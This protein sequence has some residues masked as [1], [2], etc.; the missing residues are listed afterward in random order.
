MLANKLNTQHLSVSELNNIAKNCLESNFSQVIVLG[1]V[2]KIVNHSSGHW[3]FTIK[4]DASSVDCTMFA[5]FNRNKI[6]PNVGNKII[7]IGKLTIYPAS[8]KYQINCTNLMIED[9]LGKL[10]E[11]LNKLHAKLE[12]EGLFSDIYKKPIPK[13][14]T[15]LAIITA[16]DSAAFNDILRVYE[17]KQ[18]YLCKIDFYYSLMQG[19]NAS[20]NIIFNINKI[21]EKQYD[22]ILIARGGGSKEDLFCFNDEFLVRAIVNSKIPVITGLGHEI[23][24]HLSDLAASKYY[25]TPTAAMDS[26]CY[27]KDERMIYLDSLE[28][29]INKLIRYKLNK[30]EQN[31]LYLNSKFSKKDAIIKFNSLK[32]HLLFKNKLLKQNMKNYI[33]KQDYKIKNAKALIN[34]S[35][36][37]NIYH[38]NEVLKKYSQNFNLQKFENLQ[39]KIKLNL[40]SYENNYKKSLNNKLLK[41]QN[42]LINFVNQKEKIKFKLK[43]ENNFIFNKEK[44]FFSIIKTNIKEKNVKIS[45]YH[46]V[47]NAHQA[48]FESVKEYARIIKNGKG[49]MLSSLQLGD[50]IVLKSLDTQKV[51]KIIKE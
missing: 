49:V 4:D 29:K 36:K 22:A 20:K 23:D 35:I 2:S 32:N 45:N 47:L 15:K 21:N 12:K 1:E 14:I 24:I 37:N 28:D 48:F 50:E 11:Q 9:K 30:I 16:K 27:S 34:S 17:N 51:A 25:A 13:D 6:L 19:E 10:Q 33:L 40:N 42:Y 44:A 31:F 7:V 38:K 18:S 43:L 26:L 8:G 3:Y 5:S 39:N 41:K 46:Q